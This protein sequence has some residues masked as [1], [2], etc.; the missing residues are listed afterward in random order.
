MLH[1][2]FTNLET[3][4]SMLQF[5]GIYRSNNITRAC[6]IEMLDLPLMEDSSQVAID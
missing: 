2:Y 4:R 1:E 5:Q 3:W 6:R